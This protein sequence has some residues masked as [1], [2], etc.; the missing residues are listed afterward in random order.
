MKKL[1]NTLKTHKKSLDRIS[2]KRGRGRPE[3]I[4][5]S[6]VIGRAGNYRT[7]LTEV[8][9]KLGNPLLAAKTRDEVIAALESYGAPYTGEFVPSLA[10]DIVALMG[11]SDFPKTADA[12]IGFLSDSMGGR[13]GLT[14]R[15]SRDICGKERA[16]E[17]A[18]SPHQIVRAEYYIECS[19]GY[20]GPARDNSCRKCGAGIP[21]SLNTM[22]DNPGIF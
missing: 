17:R 16:K 13:P 4:P 20:E 6:W 15:T 5:R 9:P 11:D 19:C 12:R 14:F 18:K 7:M 21:F 10:S 22:W 2:E 3:G 1:K 8:W